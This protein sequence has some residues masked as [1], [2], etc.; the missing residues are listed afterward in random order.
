[1][2][3]PIENIKKVSWVEDK[4]IVIYKDDTKLISK[5][6]DI[7]LVSD[8]KNDNDIPINDHCT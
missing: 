1:M 8:Y 7:V 2:E 3:L 6:C 4:V 5:A